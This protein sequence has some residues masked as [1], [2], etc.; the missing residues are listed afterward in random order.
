MAE[1]RMD[2]ARQ[3]KSGAKPDDKPWRLVARSRYLSMIAALIV[4][5]TMTSTL[6]DYQFNTAVEQSFQTT[7]AMTSFFGTFFAA[8]NIVAFVLQLLVVGRLLSR[9]GVAAGLAILPLALLSSSIAFLLFPRLLTAAL[10]KTSDDGLSNSVNKSSVEVLYLPISLAAKSRLKS[11]LDMFVERT[12]RSL[13]GVT[14]LMVT[15]VFSLSVNEISLVVIALLLPWLAPLLAGSTALDCPRPDEASR[16]RCG[17][18][19]EKRK[20]SSSRR[21]TIGVEC[22]TGFLPSTTV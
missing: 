11:W 14:I 3:E 9:L 18:C 7:D 16:F 2:L 8:I 17:P 12:S 5:T 21:G 20:R 22:D 1:R 19:D 13:A 15:G 4:L 6:V 10:I